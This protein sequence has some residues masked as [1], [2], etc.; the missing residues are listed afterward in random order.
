MLSQSLGQCLTDRNGHGDQSDVQGGGFGGGLNQSA[1]RR[2]SARWTNSDSDCAA[3]SKS[4]NATRYCRTPGETVA[5]A[6][7]KSVADLPQREAGC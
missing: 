5:V 7:Q 6:V 2:P 1:K 4:L 3:L